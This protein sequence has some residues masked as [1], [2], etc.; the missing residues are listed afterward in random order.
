MQLGETLNTDDKGI[1]HSCVSNKAE[2]IN[3]VSLTPVH[4]AKHVSQPRKQVVLVP[5]Y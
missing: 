5:H 3:K 1:K 4:P 2:G